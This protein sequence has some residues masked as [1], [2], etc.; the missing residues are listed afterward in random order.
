MKDLCL[1]EKENQIPKEELIEAIRD[2]L[3][4]EIGSGKKILLLVPD[5]TR[6]HSKCG[7]DRQYDLPYTG[8]V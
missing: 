2:S 7:T 5:Y 4:E 6:Y 3:K 8:R 1:Y